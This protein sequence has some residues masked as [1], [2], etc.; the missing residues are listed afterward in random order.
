MA[1][2]AG[3]I[4]DECAALA[5]RDEGS[6]AASL[7]SMRCIH[8]D[9]EVA[10]LMGVADKPHSAIARL[11]RSCTNPVEHF[12]TSRFVADM[13]VEAG[14]VTG[15]GHLFAAQTLDEKLLAPV[16][17]LELLERRKYSFRSVMSNG[18]GYGR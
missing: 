9:E 10:I 4:V 8:S 15:E 17:E 7:H 16:R 11:F 1:A 5:I 6:R 14:Q 12:T 2:Y 18:I 13:L 3:A